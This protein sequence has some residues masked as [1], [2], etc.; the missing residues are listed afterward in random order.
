MTM[1]LYLLRVFATVAEHG[2]FSQAARALYIS[3]PA[4]SKGVQSLEQQIGMR[5]LDRSHRDI[6]LTEAGHLLYDY[7]QRIFAA[8]RAAES[9]LEQLNGLERGH[10]AL[11]ASHTIG[12]YL[13]PPLMG[14]FHQRYPGVRLS[15]EIAN[16]Q[17]ILIDLRTRPLDLAFVEGPVSDANLVVAPWRTDRL[18]VIAPP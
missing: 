8:E 7:A 10:L 3:Q 2:S 17:Q 9:A 4:V 16:T 14:L 1:N 15:L 18:V 6:S 11:G 13:L 12:T 5:L